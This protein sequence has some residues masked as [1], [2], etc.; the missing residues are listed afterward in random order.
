MNTDYVDLYQQH[1]PPKEPPLA[2][3]IGEMEEMKKEGKIRA[4]G[5]S[6]WM[7]PEWDVIDDPSRV[8]CLQPNHS[9][10]WR[11]I[12]KSVLPLCEKND[13][14]TL[15]YS[16]LCQGILAGKFKDLNDIPEDSR[17]SNQRLTPEVWPQVQEV[18]KALQEVAEKYGRTMAQTAI[19]WNLDQ[20]GITCAIVGAS[21]PDQV[22]K[23]L[24]ALDWKLEQEDWQKLADVSWPLSEGLKPHDTLW[25]WHPRTN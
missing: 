22:D 3:T 15:T 2:D 4:I 23:N 21:R 17:K 19:R 18:L 20:P 24:G 25:N 8:E 5:V 7:E 14:A 10:L 13:I 6:N 12:E 9:L 16:T 11:S 1:W